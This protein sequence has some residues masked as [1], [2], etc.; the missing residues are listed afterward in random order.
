MPQVELESE[1]R[2]F[3][4]WAQ[5]GAQGALLLL[6]SS[7]TKNAR[8]TREWKFLIFASER[9][10]VHWPAEELRRSGLLWQPKRLEGAAHGFL[11]TM[12]D[13]ELFVIAVDSPS[14]AH[15]NVHEGVC[16]RIDQRA[17]RQWRPKRAK[18]GRTM[19]Q[20]SGHVHQLRP[21]ELDL[22][23]CRRR[24]HITA[25]EGGHP[26]WV[27]ALKLDHERLAR[28]QAAHHDLC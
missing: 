8:R 21:A 13:R 2:T 23:W 18:D 25:K 1:C 28:G 14:L 19:E 7:A 20:L 16:R 24:L 10:P 9:Q 5:S 3:P 4:A 26:G 15:R 6:D 17:L 12:A 22:V 11:Q 27:L